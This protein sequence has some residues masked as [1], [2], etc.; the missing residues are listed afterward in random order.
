MTSRERILRAFQGLPTDRVVCAPF[1]HF[2]Y[3]AEF[4]GTEELDYI[5]KGIELY[6]DLGFDIVF[7][8]CSPVNYAEPAAYQSER[9]QPSVTRTS[10]SDDHDEITEIKTPERVLRQVRSFRRISPFE[11][12]Q[13][14]GECFIKEAEDLEQFVKYQ[15]PLMQDDCSAITRAKELLGDDGIVC[16]WAAGAYNTLALY[17]RLDDLLMDPYLNPELYESMFDYFLTRSNEIFKQYAAAG[18]DAVVCDGNQATGSAVGPAYFEEHVL[19][20]EIERCKAAQDAGLLYL[21]HN[22]GDAASIL[23]LYNDINMN[24]YESLTPPPYGDTE[25]SE[26][27]R[28]VKP[29]IVLCGGMDQ[30]DFLRTASPDEIREK[31]RVLLEEGKKRGNF[32]LATSDYFNEKTPLQNIQAFSQ[33]ANDFGAY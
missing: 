33:A 9:W 3:V 16:P 10:S 15:P 31:V 11:V 7:R 4:Y 2:N 32:I 5:K 21:Y 23:H 20:R 22:C 26:A 30:I 25:F 29:E 1:I 12:V 14:T 18:A 27:C 17:R 24:V 28:I 8:M 6:K 19:H 13:A